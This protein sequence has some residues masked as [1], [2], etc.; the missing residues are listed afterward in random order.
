MIPKVKPTSKQLQSLTER[1]LKFSTH[2]FDT[3]EDFE[4]H[5]IK[6]LGCAGNLERHFGT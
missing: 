3:A 5:D 4:N 6:N 2:A 1:I